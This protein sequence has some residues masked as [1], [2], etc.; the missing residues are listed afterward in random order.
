MRK[1]LHGKNDVDKAHREPERGNVDELLSV[2]L[3]MYVD[4]SDRAV[5]VRGPTTNAAIVMSM[6]WMGRVIVGHDGM[7]GAKYERELVEINEA[8]AC[9]AVEREKCGRVRFY[10]ADTAGILAG[11]RFFVGH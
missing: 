3:V 4:G 8:G 2:S 9:V 11:P 10:A 6:R 7:D 5:L 1:T